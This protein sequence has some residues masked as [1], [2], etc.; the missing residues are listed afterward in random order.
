MTAMKNLLFGLLM[1]A[2]VVGADTLE[3]ASGSIH[4]G[5]IYR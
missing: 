1:V 3:L 4:E 2:G 5:E